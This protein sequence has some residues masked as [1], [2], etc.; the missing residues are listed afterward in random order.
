M[1]YT[2][3]V[4]RVKTRGR[5]AK[6]EA[7]EESVAGRIL[8]SACQLFYKEGLRATGIERV[9]VNGVTVVEGGEPT[10]ATPGTLLRSGRDTETVLP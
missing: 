1:V 9:M 10:G 3:K 6:G 8:D 7:P 4:G 5:P 2:V